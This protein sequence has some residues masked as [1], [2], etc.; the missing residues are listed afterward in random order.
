MIGH[1]EVTSTL[2]DGL[3]L[4]QPERYISF[5]YRASPEH[6]EADMVTVKT[7]H[8]FHK[9][10]HTALFERDRLIFE[11]LHPTEDCAV[12]ITGVP[13]AVPA[14]DRL[15]SLGYAT[16]VLALPSLMGS[17]KL[18]AERKDALLLWVCRQP[19]I[20]DGLK[21]IGAA[22][23][24]AIVMAYLGGSANGLAERLFR[25]AHLAAHGLKGLAIVPLTSFPRDA[26]QDYTA[27]C[28]AHGVDIV[29][30]PLREMEM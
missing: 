27:D 29:L 2:F 4:L 23:R 26:F 10:L 3:G 12:V 24:H 13:Y 21:G 19:S 9:L 14:I 1:A 20:R 30:S 6:L 8:T 28:E 5:L 7:E 15:L 17:S 18:E 16:R 22:S 25:P 11:C